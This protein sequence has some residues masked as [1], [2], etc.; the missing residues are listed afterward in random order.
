MR[1]ESRGITGAHTLLALLVSALALV[2]W[3]LV[4]APDAMADDTGWLSPSAN[5]P[6][7]DGDGF[8]IDPTNAYA[9]GSGFA[10]NAGN[11]ASTWFVTYY[12]ERHLYYDY[13]FN[14]PAGATIGGIE[15]RLDWW[16]S[17]AGQP[18]VDNEI[19]VDLSW[20]G[21]S[22]WTTPL[23]VDSSEP[24]VETTVVFGGPADLWN[25]T[26]TPGEFD[27]GNFVVR[28]H[29][30]SDEVDV[31]DFHLDWVAARVT[32]TSA[33]PG[34]VDIDKGVSPSISESPGELITYTY[35]ITVTNTGGSWVRIRDVADTLPAGFSYLT[36]ILGPPLDPDPPVGQT[37]NWHYPG[38]GLR[39]NPGEAAV[40][41]FQATSSS[42][43]GEYCDTVTAYWSPGNN[44]L[45]ESDLACVTVRYPTF[46]IETEVLGLRTRVRVRIEGDQPVILSWEI[47]P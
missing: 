40:I 31:R 26:W 6:F 37:V 22:N 9:D 43:I 29:C 33:P 13:G 8:E 41:I 32:Y 23:K 45:T 11:G 28:V 3:G 27:D 12:T 25:R 35:N 39:L 44:T 10:E 2:L 21:G 38:S 42:G 24:T 36:T 47:I 46:D 4:A 15:V 19:Q 30:H 1:R 17:D 7:G 16:L 14:I 20:N 5:N 18:G 34:P